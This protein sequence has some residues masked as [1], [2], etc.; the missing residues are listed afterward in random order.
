M[1]EILDR[2]HRPIVSLISE[3]RGHCG[4]DK[5][6]IS[7]LSRTRLHL[8]QASRERSIF[9]REVVMTSRS[10]RAEAMVLSELHKAMRHFSANRLESSLH[11]AK[12]KIC[13][14]S[15]DWGGYRRASQAITEMMERQMAHE[16]RLCVMLS[17]RF[18]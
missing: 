12:W 10:D 15:A 16:R 9:I 3:I 2:H 6:N 13:S 8:S 14:I 17:R 1:I 7:S 11:V 4:Q 5:P 18:F